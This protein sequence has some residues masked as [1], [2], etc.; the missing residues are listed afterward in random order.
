V[1]TATDRRGAY[2]YKKVDREIL[3]RVSKPT[4]YCAGEWNSTPKGKE[5]RLRIA[6]AFPD[7]YEVGMSHL[8]TRILY[9]LL[10]S[11][12]DVA[13]ERVFLPWPDMLSAMRAEGLPLFSLETRTPLS[14]F[15]VVGF[16]LQHELTYTN[17][18]E[19]LDLAGIPPY[20]AHR[21][22]RH[23]LVIAGG[24]C[25]FSAE[26]VAPFFDLMVLGDGEP[27]VA[28]LLQ[29]LRR[30]SW[31]P[32]WRRRLLDDLEEIPGVY[33]PDRFRVRYAGDGT[34]VEV[35]GGRRVRKSILESL[36]SVPGPVRQVVPM[37]AIVHDRLMV[38][39]FRGCTRG[40]R[41][42]LAG[43]IYR[44]CRSRSPE[45]VVRLALE[46]F[47]NTG[48]EEISLVS[49]NSADYPA[50]ADVAAALLGEL[51][52]KGVSVSVPSLRADA[53]SVELA[54]QLERVRRSTL[55][56]APEAGTQRLRDIINKGINDKDLLRA[57]E[58]AF[59]AGWQGLKLY[60]MIGL[61]GET[62]SDLDG[63]A[64]LVGGVRDMWRRQGRRGNPRISVSV[65]PFVPKAHTP[66]QWEAQITIPEMQQRIAHL[67]RRLKMPGVRV[68]WHDPRASR[69]EAV[70]ARGDR[71][72]SE[73]VFNAWRLGAR[74]DGWSEHF[75]PDIWEAAFRQAG[76]DPAHYAHRPRQREEVFPWDHLDAGVS[77]SFL[78]R[79]RERA[80]SGEVTPDCREAGCHGCGVCQLISEVSGS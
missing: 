62:D 35:A 33:R 64:D 34:I 51:A 18:L 74:F 14:E 54:K 67:R 1:P 57:A 9:E 78:W 12:P 16:S 23:P 80:M 39:L 69:L 3:R 10:N 63:I 77:R 45:E 44:P 32:G 28:G 46:G 37:Q 68:H 72:L 36:D 70:L 65:A 21:D 59:D 61:P 58:A 41:F 2:W 55:T 73:V 20:S 76:V 8:G 71:R 31:G 56:F 60:F 19:M 4:R 11:E 40:C 22:D 5:A 7:A 30:C 50:I 13:A 75:R 47:R 48:W 25:C 24:P 42:C 26:C 43:M 52:P 17:V 53:F 29:A 49:L 27:F 66:F 6:L 15:H 38:E 79:E